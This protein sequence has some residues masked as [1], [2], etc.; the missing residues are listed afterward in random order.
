M[1][2]N[3]LRHFFTNDDLKNN[4]R[5]N[6][7]KQEGGPE[8]HTEG[9]IQTSAQKIER[10][11]AIPP[12][13]PIEEESL[14]FG[15]TER[16]MAEDVEKSRAKLEAQGLKLPSQDEIIM[17][18]DRDIEPV[19][20]IQ[21]IKKLQKKTPPPIPEKA[22]I[23]D[24]TDDIVLEDNDEPS[25][26][27]FI[28]REVLQAVDDFKIELQKKIK[29]LSEKKLLTSKKAPLIQQMYEDATKPE[30]SP[31]ES[32]QKLQK[33]DTELNK[34]LALS[35]ELKQWA[36]DTRKNVKTET[37]AKR[38]AEEKARIEQK[39]A[40][41]EDERQMQI[42]NAE[43]KMKKDEAEQKLKKLIEQDIAEGEGKKEVQRIAEEQKRMK[44][45]EAAKKPLTPLFEDEVSG[46]RQKKEEA[47]WEEKI[48]EKKKETEG[49]YPVVPIEAKIKEYKDGVEIKPKKEEDILDYTPPVI[50]TPGRR[51]ISRT[52]GP[53]DPLLKT[54]GDVYTVEKRPRAKSVGLPP[55]EAPVDIF[56]DEPIDTEINRMPEPDIYRAPRV[57]APTDRMRSTSPSRIPGMIEETPPLRRANTVG[58]PQEETSMQPQPVKKGF[59]KRIFGGLFGK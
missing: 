17:L 8:M 42:A 16:E 33:I 29:E 23:E 14:S 6:F 9:D 50:R 26:E 46:S 52:P 32:L 44:K 2:L 58:L 48:A 13:I 59:F 10:K 38:V 3:F 7:L 39:T 28:N 11:K 19:P 30:L 31:S 27:E 41:E 40:L 15:K 25:K 4:S 22:L 49:W 24:L 51:G 56:N 57:T 35:E 54:R 5:V 21:K 1:K 53:I 12:P 55:M 37:E 20:P 18:A 36:K 47:E 34:I 43:A 45:A